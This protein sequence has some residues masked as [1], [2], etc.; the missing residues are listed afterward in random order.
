MAAISS[1]VSEFN[2]ETARRHAAGLRAARIQDGEMEAFAALV[3]RLPSSAAV[4][5]LVCA[6][7]SCVRGE[8]HAADAEPELARAISA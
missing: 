1:F 8:V 6:L 3:E 2:R 7:A 5:S 4:G